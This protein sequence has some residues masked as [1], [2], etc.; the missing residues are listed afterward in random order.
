METS[1]MMRTNVELAFTEIVQD[2]KHKRLNRYCV[3]V[4]IVS[5]HTKVGATVKKKVHSDCVLSA[6][7]V[8]YTSR[9]NISLAHIVNPP[10][11]IV[12]STCTCGCCILC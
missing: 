12:N 1:A 11:I 10:V 3:P 6:K 2:I 8:V 9:Q 4:D 5:K 7:F